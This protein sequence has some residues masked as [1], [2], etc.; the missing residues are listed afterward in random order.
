MSYKNYAPLWLKNINSL[1]VTRKYAYLLLLGLPLLATFPIFRIYIS[2]DFQLL[3]SIA[4]APLALQIRY[5]K[6]Y[7]SRYAW[8]SLLCFIL[9]FAMKMKMFFFFGVGTFLLFIIEKYKGK[10]GEL[11]GIWLILLSPMLSYLINVFTFPIRLELSA[12]AGKMMQFVGMQVQVTGNYFLYKDATFTVDTACMGLNL[13]VTG[14]VMVCFWIGWMEKQTQKKIPLSIFFLTF[15]LSVAAILAANL[16]RIVMLV[17][18]QSPPETIGHEV[19]GLTCLLCYILLPMYI[20]VRLAYHFWGK[21]THTC[22]AWDANLNLI[23]GKSWANLWEKN[24]FPFLFLLLL[25]LESYASFTYQQHRI[26]DTKTQE[27]LLPGF[28]KQIV[29]DNVVEFTQEN[30]KIYIKPAVGFWMGDHQPTVCWQA[31]GFEFTQIEETAL[32]SYTI[33]TAKLVN[34]QDTL[35]TAWWYDNGNDKTIS[36]M[37][38]R[39]ESA[40]G[41]E[42]YRLVNVAALNKE[43]LEDLCAELLEKKLF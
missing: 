30:K 14:F 5:P 36:Q 12:L 34:K 38:W 32:N 39:S 25:G 15:L 2:L 20:W 11:A 31:S 29:R 33:Y 13:F 4:L 3:V 43:T 35:H 10:L 6:V 7:S 9:F 18:F 28:Q 41:A 19:I 1:F 16:V 27:L 42:A 22:H 17:F 26:S 40:K 21:D 8:L 37:R 23:I 24:A